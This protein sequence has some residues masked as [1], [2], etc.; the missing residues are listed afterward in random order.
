MATA[1]CPNCD[2]DVSIIETV[3]WQASVCSQCSNPLPDS[4]DDSADTTTY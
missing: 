2:A 3:E 4:T 1:Y